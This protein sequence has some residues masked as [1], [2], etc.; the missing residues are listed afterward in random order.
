VL[1]MKPRASCKL[2]RCSAPELHPSP[3]AS[4]IM[5]GGTRY[6]SFSFSLEVTAHWSARTFLVVER[7]SVSE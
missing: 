1:V 4:F 3:R 7:I 2:G 6:Y 5:R